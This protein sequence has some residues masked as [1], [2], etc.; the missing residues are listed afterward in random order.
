MFPVRCGQAK[1]RRCRESWP[2]GGFVLYVPPGGLASVPRHAE[3][4]RGSDVAMQRPVMD[5]MLSMLDAEPDA[6]ERLR[7]RFHDAAER[8]WSV[9]RAASRVL[10]SK[11]F[12]P[13]KPREP[14]EEG[15]PTGR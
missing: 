4:P 10:F 15:S 8:A 3:T 1:V 9:F 11:P 13:A 7:S 2:R 12:H 14:G 5:P 6:G